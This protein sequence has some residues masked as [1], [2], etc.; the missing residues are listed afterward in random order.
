[1]VSREGPIH[2]FSASM[3]RGNYYSGI[4][5]EMAHFCGCLLSHGQQLMIDVDF[6]SL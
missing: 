6:L 2:S 5:D 1:M 4:S 3:V